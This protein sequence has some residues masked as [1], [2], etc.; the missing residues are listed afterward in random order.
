MV[1]LD[2][3]RAC[4]ER[5]VNAWPAIDTLLVGDFVL[6]FAG[7]YSSRANSAS[8]IR[9]GARLSEENLDLIEHLYRKAGL[10]PCLRL[11]PLC[12][13]SVGAEM[14]RRGFRLRDRAIGMVAALDRFVPTSAGRLALSGV[15]DAAWIRAVS[16]RQTGAK[17]DADAALA[18]IVGRVRLPAA[19]ATLHVDGRD[20]GFGMSVAERGMAEI[21]AIVIDESLRGRGLGRALVGGLMAWARA[22][23][24]RQAF[25]QVE[26]SN[27][28]AIRTYD[29]LGFRELYRYDTMAKPG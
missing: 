9:A 2:L 17:K 6:R 18:A 13:R 14:A 7:G 10:P 1:D 19:F 26:E 23:G 24:A 20:I 11:T 8:A 27:A 22:Q 16:A 15:P 4:E 12:D 21:G 28:P 3:V 25:L 5:I 29:A